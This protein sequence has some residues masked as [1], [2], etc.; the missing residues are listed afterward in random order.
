MSAPGGPSDAPRPAPGYWVRNATRSSKSCCGSSA[1][2]GGSTSPVTNGHPSV[3]GCTGAVRRARPRE[4]RGQH[5]LLE[6]DVGEFTALFNTLLINLT[7]FFRDPAAWRYLE[8][9]VIPEILSRRDDDQL[10]RLWSAGCAT[11]EEAYTLAM[12][13]ANHL[14]PQETARRVKIYATDVDLDALTQARA[15]IYSE[16]TLHDVPEDVRDAYFEPDLRGRG[17]VITPALRRTVV[18]GR[19]DLTRDPPISRR[20]RHLSQHTDVPDCGDAGVRHPAPAVRTAGERL[21]LPR[22]G[23][24]GAPRRCR[25][26]RSGEPSTPHLRGAAAPAVDRVRRP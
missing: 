17:W 7:G 18:F 25:A 12:I 15:A 14:G 9:G 5:D 16:K 21:S 13:V 10:I 2:P 26:V 6:V 11:G 19:L 23:R 3:G 22:P 24:D 8:R 20:S 4:S 1:M